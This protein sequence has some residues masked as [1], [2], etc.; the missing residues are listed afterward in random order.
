MKIVVVRKEPVPP[1]LPFVASMIRRVAEQKRTERVLA[2]LQMRFAASG[3]IQSVVPRTGRA[4]KIL[5]AIRVR[6]AVVLFVVTMR[7]NIVITHR[8]H[9]SGIRSIRP[10]PQIIITLHSI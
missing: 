6:P 2:V 8:A 4:V 7:P 9:V 10:T 1:V 3:G 5:V